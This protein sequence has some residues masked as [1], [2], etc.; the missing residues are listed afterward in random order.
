MTCRRLP[1]GKLTSLEL[2][3]SSHFQAGMICCSP[4]ALST[5]LLFF[6]LPP[7][8]TSTQLY[9]TMSSYESRQVTSILKQNVAVHSDTWSWTSACGLY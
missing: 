4:V 6:S 3:L 8:G 5:P 2:N 7:K 1:R 9:P